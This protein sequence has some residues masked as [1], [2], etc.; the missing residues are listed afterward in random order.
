M[1]TLRVVTVAGDINHETVL[2]EALGFRS[3]VDLVL[4]CLDRV[5]LLAAVR[6]SNLDAIILVG[7]IEWFDRQLAHEAVARK[8]R[9]VA[10]DKDPTVSSPYLSLPSDAPLDEIV[11]A[12]LESPLPVPT[13]TERVARRGRVTAV[14]GP[15]GAP[16]RTRI[17]IEL[18]HVLESTGLQTLLLDADPYG[19]DVLQCLNIVEELPT[20]I[21]A[22]RLASRDE[23]SHEEL[24][25]NLRR[26]QK[27]P[28]ILPGLPRHDLWPDVS[29]F[30]FGELLEVCRNSF[31]HTVADAGFC[32]EHNSHPSGVGDGRNGIARRLVGDADRTVAVCDGS[33]IGIKNFLWAFEDLLALA[34]LENVVVVVNRVR[35]GSAKE[36]SRILHKHLGKRPAAYVPDSPAV[37]TDALEAGTVAFSLK[38]GAEVR[39]AVETLAISVG[40]KLPPRGVLTK[41]GARR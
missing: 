2:A 31:E 29:E 23:L 15:K 35:S 32:L 21:W 14:W 19:G 27:G 26:V 20:L 38:A 7:P 9:V 40:A 39:A 1:S 34:E 28:A 17:A 11:R 36:V 12:C 6:G 3:D 30:G 22:A 16:G 5:E 24:S 25:A 10:V 37:M 41:L 33:P 4:R 8:V 13:S 18:A